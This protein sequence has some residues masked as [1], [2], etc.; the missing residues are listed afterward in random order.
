M[1]DITMCSGKNCPYSTICYRFTAK[2]NELRQ[3]YFSTPP[4]N[5]LTDECDYFWA[6]KK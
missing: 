5:K 1:A 3:S 2:A 6:N 4:Y